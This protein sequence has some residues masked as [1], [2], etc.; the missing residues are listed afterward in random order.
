MSTLF[1]FCH[2][3]EYGM[4]SY[5]LHCCVLWISC[6]FSWLIF[7]LL[8]VWFQSYLILGNFLCPLY[9]FFVIHMNM[10]SNFLHCCENII[11]RYSNFN[12]FAFF[13]PL[14][15]LGKRLMILVGTGMNGIDNLRVTKYFIIWQNPIT[16]KKTRW[17]KRSLLVVH[18]VQ[19]H[20][21][22]K[23]SSSVT[24]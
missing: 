11:E 20:S 21:R 5:F 13:L 24:Q 4:S 6:I 10:S 19:N 1:F 3:H 22:I 7:F 9:S 15:L 14:Y 8:I 12:F 17:L 23:Q 18:Y 2:T 16:G